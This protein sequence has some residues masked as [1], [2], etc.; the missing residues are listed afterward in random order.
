[1]VRLVGFRYVGGE[2]GIISPIGAGGGEVLTCLVGGEAGAISPVNGEAGITSP[3]ELDDWIRFR[4]EGVPGVSEMATSFPDHS[5]SML[6]SS[7]GR[8]F[9]ATFDA[10]GISVS[11]AF[12]VPSSGIVNSLEPEETMRSFVSLSF[13]GDREGDLLLLGERGGFLKSILGMS[14]AFKNTGTD[15]ALAFVGEV[16]AGE[17]VVGG[18]LTL[19]TE[20]GFFALLGDVLRADRCP[21]IILESECVL[22]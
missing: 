10:S 14:L 17:N 20:T 9:R 7:S 2:A 5:T 13:E 6:A 8:A 21:T 12:M 4:S 19:T 22:E 15:W 16:G 1:M 3:E 11:F 18:G